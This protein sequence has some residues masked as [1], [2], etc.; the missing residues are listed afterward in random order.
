MKDSVKPQKKEWHP[1]KTSEEI[2][3]NLCRWLYERYDCDQHERLLQK[4]VYGSVEEF[5]Q[6]KLPNDEWN[7]FFQS[8]IYALKKSQKYG[9][10]NEFLISIDKSFIL[11][12]NK[13]CLRKKRSI[14][15]HAQSRSHSLLRKNQ[16][17]LNQGDEY[18]DESE[19][20]EGSIEI[21]FE[22]EN[23]DRAPVSTTQKTAIEERRKTDL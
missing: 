6:T 1:P 2:K 16:N 12:N 14:S 17:L 7:S 11:R 13:Y 19:I 15:N 22:D 23:T 21:A 3:R 9:L 4:D 10:L 20:E 18:E 8:N 5:F